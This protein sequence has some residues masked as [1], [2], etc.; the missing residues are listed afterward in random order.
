MKD[1]IA[2]ILGGGQGSRLYP[3]TKDRSKPAVPI[4]GK[5]RLIDIPVSNCLNSNINK[6]F[7]VTQFN[8]ESLNK[9]ITQ[10]Y[11][12]DN[13]HRGFVNLLAAEQSMESTDWYQGTA[14]AVRK[15]IKHLS[16]YRDIKYVLILSGDQVYSMDY[17]KLYDFHIKSKANATLT[18]IPCEREEAKSFGLVKVDRDIITDFTEKPKDDATLDKFKS[19]SF[20]QANY[21][22]SNGKREYVASAGIYLFNIESLLTLLDTDYKDFG[23]EVIPHSIKTMKTAAYLFNDYWEDVGTIGSFLKA[24]LD[25][26]SPNPN[27]DFYEQRIFTNA[28]YLPSSKIIGSSINESMIAEGSVIQKAAITK[29]V[30]GIRSM[31]ANGVTIKNSV[32]LGADFFELQ[33]EKLR[34]RD[35]NIIDVGIGENSYIKNAI[36]DKNARIGKNCKITNKDN[37]DKFDGKNY[38]IRDHIVIIPKNAEIPDNTEI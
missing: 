13:F 21:P 36:I 12:F 7:I 22:G 2:I 26:A 11:R 33:R 14:D 19:R 37:K 8:S 30:I 18:L 25:F 15:N 9:H 35:N 4:G 32:L 28:R 23:K 31:I 3:L 5:Y 34:N 1:T 10:T 17:K 24:N 6:I 20:I 16:V 29:S 38:F 27:F